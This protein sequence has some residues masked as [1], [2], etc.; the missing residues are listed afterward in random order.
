MREVQETLDATAAAVASKVTS[1]GAGLTVLSWITASNLG[2]LVGI[3]IGVAGLL[4]NMYFKHR[5][6]RRA[7]LAH[8]AF[9][10]KLVREDGSPIPEQSQMNALTEMGADE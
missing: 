4:V 9:M 2:V 3:F 10:A 8:E 5:Q 7:Q 1:G 6:D